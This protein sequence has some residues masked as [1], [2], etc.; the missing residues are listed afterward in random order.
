MRPD[1]ASRCARRQRPW[2]QAPRVLFSGQTDRDGLF[3]VLFWAVAKEYLAR[4]ANT[5]KPN[6]KIIVN[7]GHR[8]PRRLITRLKKENIRIRTHSQGIA[9]CLGNCSC[10]A[11]ITYADLHGWRKCN[12]IVGNN[13]CHVGIAMTGA[14]FISPS[15]AHKKSSHKA[16]FYHINKDKL[17]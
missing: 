8:T 12:R 11:L 10:V 2:I 9:S 3:W 7:I 16:A 1:G 15:I 5:A 6:K 13:P 17:C 14:L 4:G